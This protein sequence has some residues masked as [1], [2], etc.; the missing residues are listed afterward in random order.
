[1][2]EQKQKISKL[3]ILLIVAF[4]ICFGLWVKAYSAGA[5]ATPPAVL[6]FGPPTMTSKSKIPLRVVAMN[7]LKRQR[8]TVVGFGLDAGDGGLNDE[9]QGDF[10]YMSARF[11]KPNEENLLQLRFKESELPLSVPIFFNG[12]ANR[13]FDGFRWNE[14]QADYAA[15]LSR[16]EMSF[17]ALW[18][19][20]SSSLDNSGFFFEN[21]EIRP[22]AIAANPA[23]VFDPAGF[24]MVL[25]RIG[26]GVQGPASVMLGSKVLYKVRSYEPG[27]YYCH[28]WL[29]DTLV[30]MKQLRV[31]E[32]TAVLS[33]EVPQNAQEGDAFW[34][35]VTQSPWLDV[36]GKAFVSRVSVQSKADLKDHLVWLSSQ[37]GGAINGDKFFR[38]LQEQEKVDLEEGVLQALHS[39][40]APP[41]YQAPIVNALPKAQMAAFEQRKAAQ[42]RVWRLPF[43]VSAI[44]LCLLALF[45]V[46]QEVARH[47]SW[48]SEILDLDDAS[49]SDEISSKTWKDKV[50]WHNLWGLMAFLFICGLFWVA[51]W[52]LGLT[53]NDY[54]F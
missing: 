4:I 51:D 27:S 45:W 26:F 34:V 21:G 23:S 28:A 31:S 44:F 5:I 40:L 42:L 47:L 24:K 8:L 52:V 41:F 16:G 22:K 19:S 9:Q 17:Y 38:W 2:V 39:R 25:D 53:L 46:R 13:A 11:V 36:Q 6:I 3:I 30:D 29:N 33:F 10:G 43:R 12:N 14:L 7:A 20:V 37:S 50:P 35:S 18:G 1:M 54:Q 32:K 48:K 49:S 15:Q